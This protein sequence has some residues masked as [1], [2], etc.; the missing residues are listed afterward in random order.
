MFNTLKHLQNICENVLEPSTSRGYAVDVKMLL[1]CF[2]LHV[3][4]TETFLQMFC[5][6]FILPIT[7]AYL[8]TCVQHDKTFAKNVLQMFKTFLQMLLLSVQCILQHWTE[9]KFSVRP[10]SIRCPFTRRLRPTLWAQFLP[11]RFWSFNALF[12]LIIHCSTPKLFAVKTS[13][14]LSAIVTR[15]IIFWT[16]ILGVRQLAE[17]Q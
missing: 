15:I 12:R 14:K 13:L 4:T 17:N 3:S 9:Y 5:K 1:K 10:V 11:Y 16:E 7:I 2:I 8:L 6:C